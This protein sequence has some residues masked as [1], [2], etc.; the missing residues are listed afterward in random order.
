MSNFCSSSR[1]PPCLKAIGSRLGILPHIMGDQNSLPNAPPEH[2]TDRQEIEDAF[3]SI[4]GVI[5]AAFRPLPTQTG[6]GSYIMRPKESGILSDIA[7]M[8][9]NDMETLLATAMKQISGNPVNDRS[10]LMEKIIQVSNFMVDLRPSPRLSR[11][12]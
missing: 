11:D 1:A 2:T 3:S 8:K 5:K 6:D 4:S 10:Y 12:I 9:P 7:K